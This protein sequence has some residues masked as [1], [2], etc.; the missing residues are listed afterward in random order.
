MRKIRRI[1]A[2]AGLAIQKAFDRLREEI[3]IVPEQ[4]VTVA[5]TGGQFTSIKAAVDAITDASVMKPYGIRIESGVYVEQP[6]TMKSFVNIECDV[7]GSAIVIAADPNSPLFTM[8]ENSGIKGLT[9]NGPVNSSAFYAAGGTDNTGVENCLVTGCLAGF[10]ATGAGTIFLVEECKALNATVG[11]CLLAEDGSRIGA[12]NILSY[13]AI[14]YA[15][16]SATLWFQNSAAVRCTYGIVADDGGLVQCVGITIEDATGAAIR[17]GPV[18]TSTIIGAGITCF[19]NV[20]DVLQEAAGSKVELGVSFMDANKFDVQEWSDIT[21][22]FDGQEQGRFLQTVAKDLSVGVPQLGRHTYMGEGEPYTRGMIVLTTDDTA[23]APVGDGSNF[24]DVSTEARSISG[25]TFTLQGLAANHSIL[26]GSSLAD[27]DVQKHVGIWINQT[28]AAVETV[29]KSF[30]I[31]IWDGAAW[32]EVGSM[33]FYPLGGYTYGNS[34]FLR[35]GTEFVHFGVETSTTWA[36][37]TIGGHNLYWSRVRNTQPLTT[38]PVFQ[39]F[40]LLPNHAVVNDDGTMTFHGSARFQN[41]L[42]GLGNIFGE[43]GTVVSTSINVGSGAAPTGW[44]HNFKNSEFNNVGDAIN[45]Q[46]PIP[47]GTDTSLPL[48]I[49]GVLLP[50]VGT[51]GDVTMI[52]SM[53]PTEVAGVQVADPAGGRVPVARALGN[54]ETVTSK[55]AQTSTVQFASGVTD[56]PQRIEF[57]PF[58]VTDYYPGDMLLLRLEMDNDG[59]GSADVTTM[60]AE[61]IGSKW[62]LGQ[63]V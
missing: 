5:P 42:V 51:A 62:H 3:N 57:G 18:G 37:K 55:V 8:A 41:T 60:T 53:L 44:S 9:V 4:T 16:S 20:L 22:S 24:I 26:I 48:T 19:S 49:G 11:T 46:F 23:S 59:V 21:I 52:A 25:S 13:A 34:L 7:P 32:V 28:V 50:N 30:I 39:Q 35:T 54:T 6:I 40:R 1:Q 36:K 27:G 14:A 38:A 56:K 33:A 10:H 12:A 31:E 45:W 61:V 2:D 15:S 17:T 43:N 29:A 58:D 47:L 63:K